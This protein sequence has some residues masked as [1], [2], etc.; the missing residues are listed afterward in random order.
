MAA[1]WD[2]RMLNA[3]GQ[4]EGAAG[5]EL[6]LTGLYAPQ[7]DLLR[8]PAWGR[9]LAISGEDPFLNGLMGAGEV[10]GIQGK[11]LMSQAK[12]FAFYNGQTMD[13]DTQ[14]QDQA[15]HELYLT[16]FEYAANGSGVLPGPGQAASLM[17]SYQVYELVAAP[18]VADAPADALGPN[19]GD[20][21][22]NNKVMNRVARAQWGWKG[23]FSSDYLFAMDNTETSIENGND[24]E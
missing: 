21:A 14:V 20:F 24:Q 8:L 12:H 2:P 19:G 13:A 9:N 17:C 3:W 16:S 7:V 11:G 22:C 15:A 18:G 6:G 23:F 10:S 5:R 4:V 1:S